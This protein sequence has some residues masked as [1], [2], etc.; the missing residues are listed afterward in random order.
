MQ[1]LC[2]VQGM[3]SVSQWNETGSACELL[4]SQVSVLFIPRTLRGGGGVVLSDRLRTGIRLIGSQRK[5]VKTARSYPRAM[6][7]VY[8]TGELFVP[9]R[10]PI[11][12]SVN[13]WSDM[14]LSTLEIGVA[15]FL[16]VTE[17][18]PGMLFVPAQKLSIR[19]W[20]WPLCSF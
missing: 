4:A 20:T 16:F 1:P 8:Q 9:T 10:K 12:Y 3:N 15:Q 2:L 17:S 19:L 18:L 14:W 5:R 11:R 6:F 13:T 7:T